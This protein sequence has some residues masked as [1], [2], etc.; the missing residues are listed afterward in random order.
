MKSIKDIENITLEELE[1]V[2]LDEKIAVPHG[3][4]AKIASTT[5]GERRKIYFLVSTAAAIVIAAGLSLSLL[6]EEP[7]DTFDNPYL[8]YAELEKALATVSE[9]IKRG[10]EM[11]MTSESVIEKSIEIFK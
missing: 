4:S 7:E 9:G 10:T 11:M 3:L 1:A 6:N 2:S 5:S 8:A